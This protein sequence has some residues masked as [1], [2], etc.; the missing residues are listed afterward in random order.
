MRKLFKEPVIWIFIISLLIAL[1]SIRPSFNTEGVLITSV[2]NPNITSVENSI[3]TG[4]IISHVNGF[5]VKNVND[6]QRVISQIVESDVVRLRVRR[7]KFP[8][9][10]EELDAY[11]FMAGTKNNQTD[12]GIRV[13]SVPSTK[14]Q[15]GL[16]MTGGTE[17]LLKPEEP[18]SSVELENVVNVL[19]QRINIYGLKEAP[20]TSLTDFSGDQFIK[21]ELA[22]VG[23][24]EARGLLEKQGKFE[25]KIGNNTV[26]TSD[27]IRGV[28]LTGVECSLQLYPVTRQDG[29]ISWSFLFQIDISQEG[30]KRFAQATETLGLGEC[31]DSGCQLNETIDFYIDDELL[32]DGKFF[33]SADLKGKEVTSPVITG[34]RE[35]KN[36]A[37]KEMKR[38]Q[39]ILQASKLPVKLDL[40]RMNN[41][42]PTLGRT[43][44]QNIFAVFIISLIGVNLVVLARYRKPRITLPIIFIA[45]SEIFITLGIAALINWTMD[46]A[47]IAGII[48]SV[49]TGLDDQIFITDEVLHKS[50]DE[51]DISH[52]LK[53]KIKKAFFI[54]MASFAINVAALSPLL[55][56]GAGLL[57][58]FAITSI[59]GL[60]VGVYVTR[61]AYSKIIEKL[62]NK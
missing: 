58:G 44:V 7:E 32:S 62:L 45:V 19:R 57:K 11:P 61:P 54:I 27:D 16:E 26:F 56:A 1:V 9:I 31:S 35:S 29:G 40:I 28:C 25:A 4:D 47:S 8:Y 23:E 37:Q 14:L 41:I 46:L 2:V 12:L 33:I 55:F 34:S 6:Y 15:F 53:S 48:A 22:G 50:K 24:D 42:S 3:R 13:S 49:G 38:I 39:A 21:I 10:F 30:A 52:G 18:L 43:F 5:E 59:I 60:V 17:I 20:V 36:Q 51:E